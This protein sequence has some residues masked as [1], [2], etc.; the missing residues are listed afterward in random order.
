MQ[1]Q[2]TDIVRSKEELALE[3]IQS[4][5]LIVTDEGH[6]L[7]TRKRH[8]TGKIITYAQ[9]RRVDHLGSLGYHRF[10]FRLEGKSY[11]AYAHRMV[12]VLKHGGIPKGFEINHKDGNKSNNKLSNL[13]LV[14]HSQNHL[15]SYHV[16]GQ[17][18]HLVSPE[19]R[20]KVGLA[21]RRAEQVVDGVIH[22]QCTRC[23]TWK[24][25]TDFAKLR[26][27]STLCGV[28][29]ACRQ[30]STEDRRKY[31]RRKGK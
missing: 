16:L 30:C 26:A 14:T 22:Y 29:S 5:V 4:G 7:R 12:W 6:I 25:V 11:V 24:A 27:K 2:S 9:P 20:M 10:A 8:S 21:N 18:R 23:K 19:G 1:T 17:S 31:K 15:H 13:E 28:M 3:L